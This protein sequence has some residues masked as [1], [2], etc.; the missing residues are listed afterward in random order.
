V[1]FDI[2]HVESKSELLFPV[3][4]QNMFPE[5]FAKRSE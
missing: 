2:Y 3:H 4:G 5:T 1:E